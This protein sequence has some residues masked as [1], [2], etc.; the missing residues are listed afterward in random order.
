MINTTARE[1]TEKLFGAWNSHNVQA[2]LDM[3]H[4]D[5]IREDR[6]NNRQYNKQ[7]LARTVEAFITGFPDIRYEV[8]RVMQQDDCIVACWTA[9][10][11][12]RGKMMNIPPTGKFISICGISVIE[13]AGDRIKRV[14]Y[15]WDQAGM[16]RQMGLLPELRMAI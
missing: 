14:W 8:E 5:F 3:Y 16:L 4:D 13:L 10:G 9:S 15:Q 11:H 1:F 6:A 2:V 12:H 7:E